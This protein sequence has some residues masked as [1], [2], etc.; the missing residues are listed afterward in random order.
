MK[1]Y[2]IGALISVALFFAYWVGY[3][4]GLVKGTAEDEEEE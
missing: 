1:K 3:L 4:Q 2:I